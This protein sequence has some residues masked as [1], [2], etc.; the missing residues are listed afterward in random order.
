[1]GLAVTGKFDGKRSSLACATN[2]GKILLHSPRNV[3]ANA[4][5]GALSAV[6]YLHLN[7]KITALAAGS[8][9]SE[10]AEAEKVPFLNQIKGKGKQLE[11][12]Q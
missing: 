10:T 3:L 11:Q 6:K 5:T 2:G 8:L 7:R 4:S 12:R 1:M 9:G